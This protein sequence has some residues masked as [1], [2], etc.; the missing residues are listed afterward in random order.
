MNQPPV[1]RIIAATALEVCPRFNLKKEAQALLRKRMTPWE[2]LDAL[3]AGKQY[4]AGIDFIAHALPRREGVWWACLCIQ[5]AFGDRWSEADKAACRAA[6]F[7]VYQPNEMY[8]L[9][10]QAPA[11]AAGLQSPAGI[12]AAGVYQSGD[13]L[14]PPKLPPVPPPPFATEKAVA[15]AVKMAATKVEPL[16]MAEMR[17]LFLELGIAVARGF[18]V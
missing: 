7:W 3:V 2:F 9:A 17:R 11:A 5:Q 1:V 18:Y 12:L 14:A 10:T 15:N 8:R 4:V 6:V 16:K 13:N